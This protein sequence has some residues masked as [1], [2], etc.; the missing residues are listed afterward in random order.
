MTDTT[1]LPLRGA[2]LGLAA[3]VFSG[4]VCA[5]PR[6]HG[7]AI[8]L[9][10][11]TARLVALRVK[12]AE[13]THGWG[14]E[15]SHAYCVE[16]ERL[17]ED[18]WRLSNLRDPRPSLEAILEGHFRVLDAASVV[19]GGSDGARMQGKVA[20]LKEKHREAIR[21]LTEDAPLQ[22]I[23]L[24]ADEKKDDRVL[25]AIVPFLNL[26]DRRG[27]GEK[28]RIIGAL[29]CLRRGDF[30]MAANMLSSCAAHYP[31]GEHADVV[32]YLL[33]R[34]QLRLQN[35]EGACR[36]LQRLVREWPESEFAHGA[37]EAASR[38]AEIASR[39]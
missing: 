25:G 9:R 17:S 13:A 23:R 12:A 4:G 28:A 37:K 18:V 15:L 2:S 31:E 11:R 21:V 36:T 3:F 20:M 14:A 39:R 8:G 29:C 7:S 34:V 10:E 35:Y 16:L 32:L 5:G 1:R 26:Y 27:L 30:R 6:S 33:G 24:L 22:K 19:M 38:A